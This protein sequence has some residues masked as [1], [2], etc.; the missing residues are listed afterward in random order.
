MAPRRGRS[1]R[2][3]RRRGARPGADGARRG[4]AGASSPRATATVL[5]E[6]A[7]RDDRRRRQAAAAAA[8]VRSPPAP[9]RRRRRRCVRAARRGRARALGDAR[10]RRRARRRRA[11]PRAADGRGRRRARRWR[12]RPATCCSRARSPSWPTAARP[13]RCGCS[14]TRRARRWRAGELLQ[15]ADAGTST[16]TRRALPAALRA[17]DRA[18]VRGRVRARARW[19][20]AAPTPSAAGRVRPRGSAWPSS[21]ST[22]CSTS[23]GPA[24]RTGKH[25][26][27]DLLDG[28]VTLPL[29]LAR[30]RDP[31]LAALDLRAVRTP[32]QAEAVCDAIA[33]T[34]ALE[35]A[36]AEALAMVA[37]GEGR[38]ARRCRTP[39]SGAL[40]LVADG[41][42]DRYPEAG[43]E[44]LGQDVRPPSSAATKRSISSSMFACIR[45]LRSRTSASVPRSSS[46]SK[47]ST[48]S[49]SK[50]PVP[51]HSQFGQRSETSQCVGAGLLPVDRVDQRRES[52]SGQTCRS[53]T[54]ARRGRGGRRR[55]RRRAPRSRRPRSSCPEGR[56]TRRTYWLL[57]GRLAHAAG[58]ARL[59]CCIGRR[60]P[61]TL[62]VTDL[63][64]VRRVTF[65]AG[66]AAVGAPTPG[67]SRPCPT[68]DPLELIIVLVIVLVDLRPQAAARP[69]PQLGSGMR[70]FKDSITG[71]DGERRRRR[72]RRAAGRR[73]ASEPP[74]RRGRRSADPRARPSP[75]EGERRSERAPR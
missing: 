75:L 54:R 70:E 4:A 65:A 20:A 42:V 68:S 50:T 34:G 32:E 19:Q 16:I 2:S 52:Q 60:R 6:H 5:A 59:S 39:S 31:E 56:T 69:R 33:A 49:C 3:S 36:R 11:A 41:V 28:T 38:A 48:T 43:L 47:R 35:A 25:R 14:P 23:P 66:L 53:S 17:E 26:G 15:R 9:S 40:E 22:T 55:R 45:R 13:R 1:P 46:S 29:I 72:R 12:R 58:A 57:S 74:Q 67:Y 37:D 63:H 18:A 8:R 64:P 7:R 27:T 30:E 62:T 24:E 10:P 71:K 51:V 73:R 61:R 21:C 44:V